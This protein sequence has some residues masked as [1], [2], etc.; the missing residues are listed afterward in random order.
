MT[1]EEARIEYQKG[2]QWGCMMG[3]IIGILIGAFLM[4]GGP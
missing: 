1:N 4:W 2:A 3:M